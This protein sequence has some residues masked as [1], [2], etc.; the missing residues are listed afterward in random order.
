[1]DVGD[2]HEAP[3]IAVVG[4]MNIDLIAYADRTPGPGETVMGRRFE[5]G[6]GGKGANQAVMARLLGA[7]VAMIGALGDDSYAEMTLDNFAARGIE[8]SGVARVPGSSGVAPIWVEPDGTN[9]IIV[10]PGSND[11]L[12]PDGAAA[13]IR[14]LDAVDVVVGQFEVPRAATAGGFRAAHERGSVTILNPAPA[15]PLDGALLAATDWLVPNEVEFRILAGVDAT[16]D[17][18]LAAFARTTGTRLVVTLGAQGAALVATDGRVE[19]IPAAPVEAIDSTGAGDA[20]VGAFAY[21]VAIGLG[22]S[23]AVRLGIA[24]ASDSVT[25]P[26]TQRSFPDR[27]RCATL[28][29]AIQSGR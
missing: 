6:F 10:V 23:D 14:S 8:T 21:A 7:R 22:E 2:R 4:S 11:A 24:C 13:V 17:A 26:G 5:M 16:D 18:A 19:R 29:A 3:S 20:F 15:A 27:A 28:L 12:T 25:R 9:R 1:M